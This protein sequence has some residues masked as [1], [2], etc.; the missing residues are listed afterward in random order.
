M[1]ASAAVLATPPAGPAGEAKGAPRVEGRVDAVANGRAYGWAWDRGSPGTV[2]E[3]E[4]RRGGALLARARADLPR[5]DLGAGG[6]GD[7]AFEVELGADVPLGELEAVA[8]LPGGTPAGTLAVPSAGEKELEAA[9]TPHLQQVGILVEGL[10]REQRQLAQGQQALLRRVRELAVPASPDPALPQ[11]LAGL[12]ALDQRMSALEVSL[13]RVDEVL[14]SL[15]GTVRSH[16]GRPA[17]K[18]GVSLQAAFGLVGGLALAGLLALL[19][20]LA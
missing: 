13:V 15:D 5:S 11:V 6:I 19:A 12:S 3:V 10:R 8:L 14:R 1:A 4:L 9:V 18:G 17:A 16:G 20:A 7:H 2:L